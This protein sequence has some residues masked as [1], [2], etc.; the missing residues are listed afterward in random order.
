LPTRAEFEAIVEICREHKLPLFNDEM[1][2]LLEYDPAKDRLPA[3]CD[4]Y[5]LG[6]SLA[7]MSKAYAMPGIRMGWLCT[8]DGEILERMAKLKAYTTF[9]SGAPNELLARIGLANGPAILA[10]NLAMLD[11]NRRLVA[12]VFG[13]HPERFEFVMPRVGASPPPPSAIGIGTPRNWSW[14]P[15]NTCDGKSPWEYAF[16]SR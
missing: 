8:R 9:C 14:V 2:R 6:I 4:A 1:Y 12:T 3:V 5:E 10:R 16:G 11:S 13:R 7:G 15:R